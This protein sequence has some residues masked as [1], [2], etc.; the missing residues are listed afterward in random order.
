MIKLDDVKSFIF[1][2]F[3]FCNSKKQS[4]TDIGICTKRLWA[5]A[6]RFLAK[7]N[8]LGN[9]LTKLILPHYFGA[10]VGIESV[11]AF[12][13]ANP[14]RSYKYLKD[15]KDGMLKVAFFILSKCSMGYN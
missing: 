13:E 10:G 3:E 9:G 15:Y 1:K 2:S 4:Q 14:C 11:L 6:D 5:L 8:A 12:M 7:F